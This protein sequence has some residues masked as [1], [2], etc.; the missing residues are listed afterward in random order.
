[1]KNDIK[2]MLKQA[3]RMTDEDL[4]AIY[5]KAREKILSGKTIDG[6]SPDA[7]LRLVGALREMIQRRGESQHQE[8]TDMTELARRLSRDTGLTVNDATSYLRKIGRNPYTGED[9]EGVR[10]PGVTAADL[11]EDDEQFTRKEQAPEE[12]SVDRENVFWGR[13]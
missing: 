10:K 1:V 9:L 2:P 12:R 7:S 13:E 5:K 3:E 8:R 4:S 6:L 11:D